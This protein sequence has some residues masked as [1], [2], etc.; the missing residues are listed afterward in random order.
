MAL[1]STVFKA[2]LQISDMDRAYYAHHALTM[3][4][5]PSETDERMMVRLVAFARH[6]HEHLTFAK[7]LSEDDEPDIWQK[8]LTGAIIH[9]IDVGQPDEKRILRACG[10]SKRVTLYS[11]GGNG[12]K[13]W[14]NGLSSRVTRLKNLTVF[15]LVED[16]SHAL[17][18][19]VQRTMELNCVIQDGDFWLSDPQGSIKV[20]CVLWQGTQDGMA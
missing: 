16:S 12:A 5:H 6:A 4:R 10:R 15:H 3:A 9:W 19:M 8:D 20:D 13:I 2:N 1:K 14:W 18:G 17:A 11:Y 7:G